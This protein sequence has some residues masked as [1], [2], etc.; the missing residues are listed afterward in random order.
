MNQNATIIDD[1]RRCFNL[2]P[3]RYEENHCSPKGSI[4]P[5]TSYDMHLANSLRLRRVL[6]FSSMIPQLG[7][8]TEVALAKLEYSGRNQQ[9]HDPAS[10]AFKTVKRKI[11]RAS[12]SSGNTERDMVQAYKSRVFESIRSSVSAL[13]PGSYNCDLFR[14]TATTSRAKYTNPDAVL[15]LIPPSDT[16][17]VFPSLPKGLNN[18]DCY[19]HLMISTDDVVDYTPGFVREVPLGGRFESGF[20]WAH[21]TMIVH[22]ADVQGAIWLLQQVWAEAV[23]YDV[24]FVVINAGNYEIIGY[25]NR[26]FTSV[27]VIEV[28]KQT[29]GPGYLQLHMGPYIT[30]PRDFLDRESLAGGK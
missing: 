1:I 23:K 15:Y 5:P 22:Q 18:I 2:A 26:L 27:K 10:S 30:V 11:G 16:V 20:L 24:T 14:W 9:I 4:R 7:R 6:C 29:E 19:Q 21:P 25:R 17:N 13:A 3:P 8:V 12:D 28:S